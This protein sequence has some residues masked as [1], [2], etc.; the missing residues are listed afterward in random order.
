MGRL[1]GKVAII[2]GAASGMGR[3][4]A[5]RFAGEGAAVVIADLNEEGGA[6]AARECKENGGRA[7]FQKTDVAS[8][9]GIKAMVERAVKEFGRLD[10]TFNNA[11]LP[12]A[13]GS[14]EHT[15]VEDWDR[16]FAV[17]TRGVFLGI[18]HSVPEMRKV[19][20]GSIISTASV[21]GL[22][23][24]YGPHAYSAAK[25][26]VVNLTRSAALEVAK[27]KIRVNCI[28]PGGINTPIFNFLIPDPK[29]MEQLLSPLQPL[30][31]AGMPEDI[32]NMALFLA[33]DESEWI[34]GTAMVVDGGIT[35]GRE[36]FGDPQFG[37][38][39][40]SVNAYVG[41]SYE[42]KR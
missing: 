12:G 30:R 20:G 18:K 21:A 23:G 9:A 24:G 7:A 36:I 8:E 27:H 14:I 4:A 40:Y 3:A 5:V 35:A 26:G 11:G 2:T 1:D 22:A 34:T 15:S 19:G 37:G 42:I 39:M 25:A 31:R 29:V 10:I 32:A 6:A 17:L 38:G 33:S 28:C 41:P 13:L 16:T